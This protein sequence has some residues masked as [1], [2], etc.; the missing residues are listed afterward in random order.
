MFDT[1]NSRIL[2]CAISKTMPES[3]YGNLDFDGFPTDFGRLCMQLMVFL[4]G[5]DG[6]V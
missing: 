1:F 2:V 3:I 6:R 5:T 4:I